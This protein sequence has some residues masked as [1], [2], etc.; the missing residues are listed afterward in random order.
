MPLARLR[1]RLPLD[2]TPLVAIATG[3][4]AVLLLGLL[5]AFAVSTSDQ[6][7]SLADEEARLDALM[8]RQLP[9]RPA[10]LAAVEDDG[11]DIRM[12]AAPGAGAAASIL[13]NRIAQ[14]ASESG[15]AFERLSSEPPTGDDEHQIVVRAEGSGSLEALQT[16]LF[17]AETGFPYLFVD[18]LEIERDAEPETDSLAIVATIRANWKA[19]QP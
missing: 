2:R 13:Q 16:F 1:Q 14:A 6:A 4:V 11:G 15:L 19:A 12:I 10:E 7:T 17:N 3:L 5:A 9:E 8:R 18:T